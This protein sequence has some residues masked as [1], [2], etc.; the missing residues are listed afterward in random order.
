MKIKKLISKIL[1]INKQNENKTEIVVDPDFIKYRLKKDIKGLIA[2]L[3][4]KGD[5][6]K[7]EH[8][9]QLL[10][11]IMGMNNEVAYNDLATSL[12][13]SPIL[14]ENVIKILMTQSEIYDWLFD[15]I[16]EFSD[17]SS[18]KFYVELLSKADKNKTFSLLKKAL[19]NE[20][21]LKA[22]YAAEAL[23][24][25]NDKKSAEIL[26]LTL[27]SGK[28]WLSTTVGA[29][30][31][32][33]KYNMYLFDDLVL[34]TKNENL[35][36]RKGALIAITGI[37]SSDSM[38]FLINHLDDPD[39]NLRKTIVK[40][41]R[42]MGENGVKALSQKLGYDEALKILDPQ[43]Y[44]SYLD[45]RQNN[46]KNELNIQMSD[47]NNIIN[48]LK[49]LSEINKESK[50]LN[51]KVF[52][53]TYTEEF[54][55]VVRENKIKRNEFDF[56]CQKLVDTAQ[57]LLDF[58]ETSSLKLKKNEDKVEI[59][60]KNLSIF[61]NKL[62]LQFEGKHNNYRNLKIEIAV[63]RLEHDKFLIVKEYIS[64]GSSLCSFV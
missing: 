36:V 61:K 2:E 3:E 33:N 50:W 62:I 21:E 30:L 11:S 35:N 15:S 56:G 52:C 38:E 40:R 48:K 49:S 31:K 47:I 57:Q 34:L 46:Y 26:L 39:K 54:S 27:Q 60:S 7:F 14:Q 8:V 4:S 44:Q 6:I 25:F 37:N 63:V 20:D 24:I 17:K 42:A 9:N 10:Q 58:W 53:G 13:D 51:E 32:H 59:T 28:E 16:L 41:L 45:K 12:I 1:R 22:C 43:K 23:I 18:R 19:N 64:A 5:N 55:G 29:V